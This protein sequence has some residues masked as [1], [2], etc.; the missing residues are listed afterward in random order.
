MKLVGVPEVFARLREDLVTELALP[1]PFRGQVATVVR[2]VAVVH[3]V[4]GKVSLI[5]RTQK[6]PFKPDY[7]DSKASL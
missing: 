1:A 6:L 2:R 3:L 7:D 5:V 4:D